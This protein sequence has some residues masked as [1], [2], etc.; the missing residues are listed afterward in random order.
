MPTASMKTRTYVPIEGLSTALVHCIA[1]HIPGLWLAV[2]PHEVDDTGRQ[3]P[4]QARAQAIC[5]CLVSRNRARVEHIGCEEVGTTRRKGPDGQPT[6][7]VL[8]SVLVTIRWNRR[9]TA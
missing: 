8:I 6:G 3:V 4:W 7:P 1:T 5:N 9:V 2:K